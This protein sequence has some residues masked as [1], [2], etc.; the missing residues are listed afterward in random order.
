MDGNERTGERAS[1]GEEAE[2]PLAELPLHSTNLLTVLDADGVIQY[3]SPSIERIYGFEQAELVGESVAQ[4]FHP[5]DR[6]AV[7]AAFE[8]VVSSG[9]YT[10]EA[11]EYRHEQADGTY[12]WVET[13]MSSKATSQGYFVANTRDI[14]ERK[15]RERHLEAVNDR[16]EEFV[17]VVSHDLRNPLNVAQARLELAREEVESEHLADVANAHDR[18][19]TLIAD[20]LSLS[21]LDSQLTETEPVALPR[22]AKACWQTVA[23]GEA[24]IAIETDR[25]LQADRS[26]LHQ[27]LENL[28]RNAVE[29]GGEAVTVTVSDCEDGFYVEDDGRGIPAAE[30]TQLFDAGQSIDSDGT[31][32]GL[33]IVEQIAEAHDWRVR[34]TDGTDGGARFEITNLD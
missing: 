33:S 28:F 10:V 24:A 31:G 29:H 14:S 34:V 3:E 12:R 4:Y 22:C 20:L 17:E 32:L 9:E 11:A 5:A 16:L 8:E 21:Q 18:M 19:E 27:L 7:V 26:R 1:V 6:E 23:T 15:H 13:I 2:I 25:Q 30:R